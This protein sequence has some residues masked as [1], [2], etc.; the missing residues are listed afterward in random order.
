MNQKALEER[1]IK[2]KDYLKSKNK[3]VSYP[4]Q[5]KMLL[6]YLCF[7]KISKWI[8]Y[9]VLALLIL[10]YSIIIFGIL[11]IGINNINVNLGLSLI[12]IIAGILLLVATIM[13]FYRKFNEEEK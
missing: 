12:L 13:A 10:F 11:F 4:A 3:N 8:R 5:L 6:L 9:P 7:K 1:K 2:L